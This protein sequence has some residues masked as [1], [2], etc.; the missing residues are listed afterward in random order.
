MNLIR[1][2]RNFFC[3]ICYDL[4]YKRKKAEL[5]AFRDLFYEIYWFEDGEYEFITLI[6][7]ILKSEVAKA[8]YA[9][10]RWIA[11]KDHIKS[12][13]DNLL[14]EKINQFFNDENIKKIK[15]EINNINSWQISNTKTFN[16]KLKEILENDEIKEKIKGLLNNE[17]FVRELRGKLEDGIVEIVEGK[18]IDNFKF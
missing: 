8:F 16:D 15:D 12:V 17:E 7:N 18:L 4:Y 14:Q 6:K 10:T 11:L 3:N 13:V 1:K 9:E 5:E 2:I